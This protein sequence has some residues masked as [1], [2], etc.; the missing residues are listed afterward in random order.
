[1]TE[2][3]GKWTMYL[4]GVLVTAVIFIWLPTLT[5][6]VIANDKESRERDAKVDECSQDRDLKLAAR[7]TKLQEDNQAKFEYIMC[8]LSEIKTDLKYIKQNGRS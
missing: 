5:N 3:N 4:V 7:I 1:M 8:Q 6:G 2:R